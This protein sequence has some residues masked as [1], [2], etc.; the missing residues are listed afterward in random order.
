MIVLSLKDN[1]GSTAPLF[2]SGNLFSMVNTIGLPCNF[3]AFK[4]SPAC[5][6]IVIFHYSLVYFL[7]LEQDMQA[8]INKINKSIVAPLPTKYSGAL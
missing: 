7:F 2:L 3:Y 5:S 6:A 8:L 4:L 1:K